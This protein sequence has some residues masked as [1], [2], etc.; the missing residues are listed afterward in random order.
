M[1]FSTLV[2][3]L[4]DEKIIIFLRRSVV[5]PEHVKGYIYIEAFKQTHVKAA[6]GKQLQLDTDP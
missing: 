4:G 2:K 6:I 5:A 3:L 1:A